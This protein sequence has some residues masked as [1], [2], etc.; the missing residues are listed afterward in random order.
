[1]DLDYP[2]KTDELRRLHGRLLKGWQLVYGP[3]PAIWG[4]DRGFACSGAL[5]NAVALLAGAFSWDQRR[6][7]EPN[8][9]T[10]TCVPLGAAMIPT[11][12]DHLTQLWKGLRK[13]DLLVPEPRLY[14]AAP[15]P[16]ADFLEVNGCDELLDAGVPDAPARD[17][18]ER[19][20][21]L[22]DVG[23]GPRLVFPPMPALFPV[24]KCDETIRSAQRFTSWDANANVPRNVSSAL[25]QC[26]ELHGEGCTFL[27]RP[28]PH[29]AIARFGHP[30][31]GEFL[32]SRRSRDLAREWRSGV[33]LRRKLT[34][35]WARE[36]ELR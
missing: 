14:D 28:C 33:K 20:S 1:M 16:L 13:G 12:P 2:C 31:I 7:L 24:V 10:V 23:P 19:L 21:G 3:A 8:P 15:F 4:L 22:Y 34:V 26:P 5:R 6:G 27:G 9:S 11:E 30:A 35:G 17:L 18:V 36:L 25:R 29:L 32:A